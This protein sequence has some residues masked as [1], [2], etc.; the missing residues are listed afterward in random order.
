[1]PAK[2]GQFFTRRGGKSLS[3]SLRPDGA[4]IANMPPLFRDT[5][6]SRLDRFKGKN[7][8]PKTD[9]EVNYADIDSWFKA[10]AGWRRG[11][12]ERFKPR[13]KDANFRASLEAHLAENPEWDPV[14]HPEKYQDKTKPANAEPSS[15]R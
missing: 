14:L 9:H 10:G 2:A 8:E 13:L 6:P 5:L 4:F 1:M 11:F 3:A 12:V 15:A 7:A